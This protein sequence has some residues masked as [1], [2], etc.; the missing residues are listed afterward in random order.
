MNH[1]VAR[2]IPLHVAPTPINSFQRNCLKN[3]EGHLFCQMSP[4]LCY[5][6]PSANAVLLL[7]AGWPLAMKK[8]KKQV[9]FLNLTRCKNHSTTCSE[10][11]NTATLIPLHLLRCLILAHPQVPAARWG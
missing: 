10:E 3:C 11:L 6:L 4:P 7:R 5:G 1:S 8:L 9:L 2:T